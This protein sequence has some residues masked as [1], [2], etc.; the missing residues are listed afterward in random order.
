[1]KT[2][3]EI[4]QHIL[5]KNYTKRNLT[6][7]IA[8]AK[9]AILITSEL[10]IIFITAIPFIIGFLLFEYSVQNAI[11]YL[12]AH[13]LFYVLYLKKSYKEELLPT[14]LEAKLELQALREVKST[15]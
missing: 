10:S 8:L 4:K 15:K 5:E 3:F 7:K 11:I 2:L 13:F 12:T 14:H 1:M 6:K 9:L